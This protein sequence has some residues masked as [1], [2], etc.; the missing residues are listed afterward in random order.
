VFRALRH[1][2]PVEIEIPFDIE[3][4]EEPGAQGG[5]PQ[6][7]VPQDEGPQ[8]EGRPGGDPHGSTALGSSGG[9]C[10]GCDVGTT[11]GK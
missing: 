6:G 11:T 4:S 9:I 10:Q 2:S 3:P 5:G 7:D 8:G 1:R